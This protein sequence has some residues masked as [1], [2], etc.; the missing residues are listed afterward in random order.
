[1]ADY[2]YVILGGGVA[3]G[4]AAKEFVER[5]VGGDVCLISQ[6]DQPPYDR[7]P[8]SK[9]VLK[10]ESETSDALIEGESYY[11]EHGI[12]LRLGS[13]VEEVDFPMRRLTMP[14]DKVGF[15]KLLIATGGRVR[16]LEIP[17]ADLSGV[18]YLR[19]S[20]HVGQIL[21]EAEGAERAVVIGGS[22]IGTEVSA[23][24]TE[25]GVD[26]TLVYSSDHL[27]EGKPLTPEM[28]SYFEKY[29]R[30]KGVKLIAG[31]RPA[32]FEGGGHVT[33]VT[34]ES[35][36]RLDADFVVAG[37][38][39]IPNT[40]VFE[41]TTLEL[42]NGIVVDEHLETNI[43]GVFAAGDIARYPDKRYDTMRRIEHWDVARR[44]GAH[45]ARGMLDEK[46]PYSEIPYFFSDVFDLSWEYWGDRARADRV[47]YRGDIESG[48]FSAWWLR[49]KQVEAAFVMDRPSDEREAA[50]KMVAEAAEVDERALAAESRPLSP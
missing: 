36:A 15:E 45:A 23:S 18:L 46:A 28:A 41:S 10:G 22:F 33:G 31:T 11:D 27:L 30:Q 42:D 38:G 5:G 20:E 32:S 43:D 21:E 49:G 40:E 50:Q 1:M 37:V 12:E 8:L 3:A 9:S 48:S 34:L 6:E 16:R 35:G 14:D 4:Y 24:L 17:G 13:P 26:V 7:P 25:R 47:V 44:Q 2:R 19:T 39:V 29:F